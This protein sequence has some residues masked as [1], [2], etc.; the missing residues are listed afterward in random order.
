M[1][2]RISHRMDAV[3]QVNSGEE[4]AIEL[5]SVSLKRKAENA[6]LSNSIESRDETPERGLRQ[7]G[8]NDPSDVVSEEPT[9]KKGRFELTETSSECSWDLDPVL[10][11]YANK[12]MDNFVSNQALINEIMSSNPVPENLKRGKILDL[13]LRELLAEQ[14]KY[15][16]L[17]QDKTLGNLQQRIA[18][19]YGSLTNIWTAMETEKESYLAEEGETNPLFEM[20]KLFD[21]V[22]LLLCQAMNSCSDIWRFNV[23]MSFVGDKKRVE[24]MLKDNATAFLDA[25]NMLFGSKYEEL[26]KKSLSS[27]NRSKELFDSVKNQR[28]SKKGSRRQ[29]FRKCPYL[30][31]EEI[32]GEEFSKL[33]VKPCKN[34]TLQE[35]KEDVRMNLLIVPSISSTDLLPAS[36]FCKIHP[37][38]AHLFPVKMKQLSK[39]GRVKHFVN[40]LQR[41]TNDPVI[42]HIVNGYEIPFILPPR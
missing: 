5:A 32:G 28:P 13:Y 6:E 21:Q 36:V 11:E 10:A 29:P 16:C 9:K 25:G 24:S 15:I 40:N 27:K 4:A 8:R 30:E 17:N 18:F 33:L 19:V 41:L 38:V 14:D 37:L 2:S 34:N 22:N 7:V 23:L 26:V 20:S 42:L 39:A 35:D 31:A 12:Y 3:K 1:F